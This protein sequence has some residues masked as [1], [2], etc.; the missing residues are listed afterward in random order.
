[1]SRKKL[2]LLDP[3]LCREACGGTIAFAEHPRVPFATEVAVVFPAFDE[4]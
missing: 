2:S 1:M 3:A 4:N